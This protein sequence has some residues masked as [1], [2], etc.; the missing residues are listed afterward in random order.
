MEPSNLVTRYANIGFG[1]P[2]IVGRR[3]TVHTVISMAQNMPIEELLEDFELSLEEVKAAV[4]YCKTRA[5]GMMTQTTD[6]Y[7]DGCM[8]RSIHD[9][10]KFCAED[11]DEID[12]FAVAKDGKSAAL[13]T[14][15][16]LEE[17]EFGN[18]GWVIA[19]MVERK[20]NEMGES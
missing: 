12:G 3:L 6:K 2:V 1:Q 20:L 5:C 14:L 19:E 9:G 8:L 18:M 10:W 4:W 17:S 7:C 13:M 11:Y 15:A 16:E